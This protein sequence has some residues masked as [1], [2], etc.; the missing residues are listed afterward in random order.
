MSILSGRNGQVLYDSV[1]ASPISPTAIAS[2]NSWKLS[3]KTD[4]EEVS[5]FGD[6]NKVYIPGLRDISGSFGGFW[7]S[8]E[9]AVKLRGALV[10]LREGEIGHDCAQHGQGLLAFSYLSRAVSHAPFFWRAYA[11]L[12]LLALPL[13]V[14]TRTLRWGKRVFHGSVQRLRTSFAR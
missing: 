6:T 8:A 10:D 1:P 7:N 5:C 11:Y 9:L 3:L 13:P 12:A 2:L 14:R 4:Y